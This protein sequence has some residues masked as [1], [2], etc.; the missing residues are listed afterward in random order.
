MEK[1]SKRRWEIPQQTREKPEVS[2]Q[3]LTGVK[4]RGTPTSVATLGQGRLP[5]WLDAEK[6]RWPHRR[7]AGAAGGSSRAGRGGGARREAALGQGQVHRAGGAGSARP[8]LEAAD[9]PA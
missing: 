3:S 2:A 6:P 5:N 9:S 4:G 1:K 7:D 8:V